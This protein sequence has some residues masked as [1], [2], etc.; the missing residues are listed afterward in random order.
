MERCLWQDFFGFPPA[1][2]ILF[3]GSL[4]IAPYPNLIIFGHWH[5]EL[6]PIWQLFFVFLLSVHSFYHRY[7]ETELTRLEKVKISPLLVSTLISVLFPNQ[8]WQGHPFLTLPPLLLWGH[9]I[10]SFIAPTRCPLTAFGETPQTLSTDK[11][12]KQEMGSG[13]EGQTPL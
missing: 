12:V 11:S 7:G 6:S 3:P 9:L 8:L 1:Y 2:S 5:V 4:R 10:A 13:G